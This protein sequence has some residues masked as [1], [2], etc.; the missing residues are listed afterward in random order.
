VS[1]FPRIEPT[2]SPA[3]GVK[4]S[5][6]GVVHDCAE[7]IREPEHFGRFHR[8]RIDAIHNRAAVGPVLGGR[9]PDVGAVVVDAA[10]MVDSA[11]AEDQISQ[12]SPGRVDLEQVAD[13]FAALAGAHLDG[14]DE[15]RV[16]DLDEPLRVPGPELDADRT[17]RLPRRLARELHHAPGHAGAWLGESRDGEC[18]CDERSHAVSYT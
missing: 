14:G 8:P 5:T 11:F 9:H 3:D 10:R 18:T 16:G 6:A 7:V 2:R 17:R 13:A 4:R 12:Q 15:E 1:H